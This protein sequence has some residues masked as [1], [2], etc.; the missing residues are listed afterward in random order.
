MGQDKA[1]LP[2]EGVPMVLRV[3]AALVAGRCRPQCAVGGDR[4]RLEALDLEV[5]ADEYPGEGPLGGVIT[6]LSRY[7]AAAVVVV[8][9]CDLPYLSAVSVRRLVAALDG[10][11][12]AVARAGSAQP[13]CAAW[14]PSC[15]ASLRLQF[16]AGE[17]RLSAVLQTLN[18]IEV[19]VNAQ[20]L[21][22]L[23]TP[24]DLPQ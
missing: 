5:L 16:A 15:A 21:A 12:V 2:V 14:R 7:S 18:V 23:N 4:R 1:L 11:D 10:H 9:A 24:G 3:V 8:V 19:D 13:V 20:D 17:R 6:V 22:N